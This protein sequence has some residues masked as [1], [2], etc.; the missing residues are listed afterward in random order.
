MRAGKAPTAALRVQ[1]TLLSQPQPT[2]CDEATYADSLASLNL[3]PIWYRRKLYRRRRFVERWPDL[4]EWFAA[5][6]TERVGRRYGE[7]KHNLIC[8][9][10]FEARPY[11]LFLALRGYAC[12][13]YAWLL[14][15]DHLFVVN[16]AKKLGIDFG[17]DRL[18]HEAITLGYSAIAAQ[19]SMRWAICRIALHTG[20]LD[21]G[22]IRQTHIDELLQAVR[23]FSNRPDITDFYASFERYR[24]LSS[25]SWGTQLHLLQAVLY[26]RDQVAEPPRRVMPRF[27]EPAP[28]LPAM[29]AVVDRWLSIRKLTDRPSTIQGLEVA[30]RY[31]LIWIAKT[32][33][34]VA[35]FADV[36]REHLLEYM[37]VL[38]EEPTERTG[39]PLAPATRRGRISALSVFF[40]N[41]TGWGWD[42][43]PTRPLLTAADMPRLS[44][45][46]PR[47]IPAD[48][49]DRLMVAVKVLPCPYQRAAILVARWSGAR[50]NEIIRLAV[51]CL[52]HYPDGTARLRLPAGKTY[53]ERLVPIHEEAAAALREVIADRAGRQ[54]RTL[55]DEVSGLPTQY[56]FMKR[57]K[58][59]GRRYLFETP[60]KNACEAAGLIDATGRPTVHTHRFRHTVGTQLAERG[61]KLHTI[62][63][64][65]GHNSVS[66]TLVYAQISDPEVLKD[67][68]AVL[69][70]GAVIAG[71]GIEALRN[72]QLSASA[73][74]W[75]KCNFLK[76]ELELGHC[77]RLPSEGPCECDLYL[78]CAKF[79]TTPAYAPRLR[80]RLKIEETL[81]KDAENRG[82][83]R[84]V[85]RHHATIGRIEQLLT[86]LGEPLALPGN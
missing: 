71:P 43:V 53:R 60:L 18:V 39:Q 73:I 74:D 34:M 26:H 52:D 12:L 33:P 5:P 21:P 58:L 79:V 55:I 38:A 80:E 14:A 54:E 3:N 75:L 22:H 86:D 83:P 46:V 27:A 48:E 16:L 64:V 6:L 57:G 30:L 70:P 28:P 78:N 11:I 72:G 4:D 23:E 56:L 31:F 1:A 35:S 19:R 13:D 69:G 84:E 24:W 68:K 8:R 65:L 29:Q 37:A 10:A 44:K 47:F 77:L 15:V 81:A 45:L 49:L 40:R 25:H 42:D 2:H 62:M 7:I 63:R 59:L 66:M 32:D 36:T 9:I 82:W 76:T 17:I 67:Y 50:Q 20:D 41:T 51:D 61:A 85:E